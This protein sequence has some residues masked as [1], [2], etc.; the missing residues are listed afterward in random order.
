M[1]IEAKAGERPADAELVEKMAREITAVIAKRHRRLPDNWLNEA[2]CE[3]A[4]AALAIARE[5]IVEECARA[6]NDY[7]L[8]EFDKA[9]LLDAIRALKERP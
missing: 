7:P 6:I 1:S 5:H 3:E 8:D 9:D 4:R 2:R